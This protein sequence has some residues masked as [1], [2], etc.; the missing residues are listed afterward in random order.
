MENWPWTL[1]V[2]T[3]QLADLDG[4]TVAGPVSLSGVQQTARADA[5][6]RW[7]VELA[8]IPLSSERRLAAARAWAA[9][10]A[11][12][13]TPAVIPLRE[14][15]SAPWPP[16]AEPEPAES[17]ALFGQALD[18]RSGPLIQ[19]TIET[20]AALRTTAVEIRIG[21]SRHSEPTRRLRE[22]GR[23]YTRETGGPMLDEDS[24]PALIGGEHFSIDHPV[25]GWRLYRI[26]QVVDVA[27]DV[28]SVTIEPPLREA[29]AAAETAEFDAP[30]C[31]MT[32]DPASAPALA[33][34]TGLALGQ[35]VSAV[36]REAP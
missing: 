27:G 8:D 22:N 33:P 13:A 12:G 10:L 31:V 24:G 26:V 2:P 7:I 23:A 3:E 6:G 9:Y 5:G 21:L 36:F 16:G 32:L 15:D 34:R 29:V 20:A 28:H 35:R 4:V 14:L 25:K 19:A 17:D 11:R 18:Y 30:R 1:L